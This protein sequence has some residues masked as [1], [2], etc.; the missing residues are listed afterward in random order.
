MSVDVSQ[1]RVTYLFEF[2]FL[3]LFR[4]NDLILKGN[5]IFDAGAFWGLE[6]LGT[7]DFSF[8]EIS[9]LKN[10]YFQGIK[11]LVFF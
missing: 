11:T 8:N 5:K 2:C 9:I 10:G 7:L 3:G 4:L 1:N 6:N